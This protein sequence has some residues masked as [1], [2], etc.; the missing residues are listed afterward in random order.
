[1]IIKRIIQ[2][3]I[4]LFLILSLAAVGLII[5]VDPNRYKD[6]IVTKVQ[7]QIHRPF[8]INGDIDWRFWPRPGFTLEEV[9]IGQ[10][11]GKNTFADIK[12][13]NIYPRLIPLLSKQIDINKLSIQ[14]AEFYLTPQT[15]LTITSLDTA[16]YFNM[17]NKQYEAQDIDIQMY[18]TGLGGFEKSPIDLQFDKLIA[19]LDTHQINISQITAHVDKAK[20][21]GEITIKNINTTPLWDINA[22]FNNLLLQ[23]AKFSGNVNGNAKV[24][25]MGLDANTMI[26]TL[27]GNA[28]IHVTNG[29]LNN[30]DLGYWLAIGEKMIASASSLKNLAITTVE[31]AVG[32]T[33]THHTSFSEMS[34][35]FVIKQG[36]AQNNDLNVQGHAMSANGK[37]RVDL[38]NQQLNYSV[39]VSSAQTGNVAI[40][41]KITG[42]IKNPKVE[43]DMS[44]LQKLLISNVGVGVAGTLIGGPLV[45]AAA[46]GGETLV[47]DLTNNN[48]N[49]TPEQAIKNTLK[50]LLGQ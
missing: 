24:T 26:K 6:L 21:I 17:N 20:I 45:G 18:I 19:D 3:L 36:I 8:A 11:N 23:S 47:H 25:A 34:A 38:P 46:V 30:I 28:M 31:A 4:A 1:M 41:L 33:N 39:N 50:G 15:K 9:H 40:P 42:N 2:L 13:L 27:N 49:T 22:T 16:L 35:T 37:G 12:Q 43:I 48:K 14:D 44:Q 10:A 5:F 29:V 32:K 7:E